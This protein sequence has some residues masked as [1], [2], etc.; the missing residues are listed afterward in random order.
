MLVSLSI[1]RHKD[2]VLCDVVPMQVGHIL[3]KNLWKFDRKV[4][5]DEFKNCY[6]FVVDGKPINLAPLP[7][8]EVYNDQMRIKKAREEEAAKTRELEK[9]ETKSSFIE[10]REKRDGQEVT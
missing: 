1:G 5:H 10:N 4:M 2:E 9:S 8:K 7:T 6:S 3:L